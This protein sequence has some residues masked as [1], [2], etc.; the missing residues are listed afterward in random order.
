LSP[1]PPIKPYASHYESPE[2]YREYTDKNIIKLADI[3][4]ETRERYSHPPLVLL[5]VDEG[6]FS[7][8]WAETSPAAIPGM[9]N[10]IL[11][12]KPFVEVLALQTPEARLSSSLVVY[13]VIGQLFKLWVSLWR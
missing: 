6:D 2:R 8:G 4:F 1:N 12:E 5:I 3:T 7:E 10:I 11:I 9:E 13:H